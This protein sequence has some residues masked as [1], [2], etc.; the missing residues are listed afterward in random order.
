[1]PLERG[2]KAIK[3]I[4]TESWQC[5]HWTLTV[6]GTT[7]RQS[8]RKMRE[9]QQAYCISSGDMKGTVITGLVLSLINLQHFR[10]RW[11]TK[12]GNG[13]QNHTNMHTRTHKKQGIFNWLKE[14]VGCWDALIA[15]SITVVLTSRS[16]HTRIQLC[17]LRPSFIS[18]RT[19]QSI[20]IC[21]LQYKSYDWE[22]VASLTDLFF[23]TFD[24]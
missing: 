22:A 7:R 15:D 5:R 2:K 19:L 16:T 8:H 12:K 14:A 4:N 20:E 11:K 23:I 9:T 6:I 17:P 21:A 13:R 24:T 10:E 3:H 18:N 1:M